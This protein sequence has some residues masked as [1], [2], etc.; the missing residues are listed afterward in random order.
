VGTAETFAAVGL[1]LVILDGY[2]ARAVNLFGLAALPPLRFAGVVCAVTA[3]VAAGYAAWTR[4]TGPR[5]AALLA[6]QPAVPPV[7]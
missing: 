6:A 7:C 4:L 3:V 2:A 1:L 5:L